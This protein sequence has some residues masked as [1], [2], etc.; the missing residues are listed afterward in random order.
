MKNVIHVL[1]VSGSGT[2]MARLCLSA[3]ARV[4]T[5]FLRVY[6]QRRPLCLSAFVRVA[7]HQI[8]GAG[9]KTALCLSA[10]ARVATRKNC[11]G[12]RGRRF[13]T[14]HSRG[15]RPRRRRKRA[16]AVQLCHSAFARVATASAAQ[17]ELE[18]IL[19]HSVF[20]RV[21]TRSRGFLCRIA[22][23]LPQ[24][25]RAGCDTEGDTDKAEYLHFATAHSC[26]LRPLPIPQLKPARFFATAHSCG[27]RQRE[28]KMIKDWLALP[29][30]IRAGCD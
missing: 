13:A 21:A 2:T 15:L 25:I 16:Q 28:A 14:A 7:T 30:R 1:G 5:G 12:S 10:F 23:S 22:S 4:A 8:V 11:S 18:R 26:G 24:R 20:V 27:L 6:R 29:Q 9:L 19:C 3:F 17:L